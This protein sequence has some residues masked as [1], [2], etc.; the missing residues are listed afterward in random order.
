MDN[1]DK[2]MDSVTKK[3]QAWRAVIRDDARMG[4]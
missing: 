2:N 1:F 4:Q 3:L